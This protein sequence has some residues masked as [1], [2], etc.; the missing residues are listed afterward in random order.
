MLNIFILASSV[1][2]LLAFHHQHRC[3]GGSPNHVSSPSRLF[4]ARLT[5]YNA[6]CEN[7]Q[8]DGGLIRMRKVRVAISCRFLNVLYFR[9]YR[10]LPAL[11][12]VSC[13]VVLGLIRLGVPLCCPISEMEAY[14]CPFILVK[15]QGTGSMSNFGR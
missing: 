12:C 5:R 2:S 8:C 1:S 14:I 4:I 7:S 3:S 10:A 9:I 6:L 13:F 15:T 11:M